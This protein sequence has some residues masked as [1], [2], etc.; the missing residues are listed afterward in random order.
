LATLEHWR[1]QG[2]TAHFADMR[3]D[4]SGAWGEVAMTAI[5][6]AARMDARR[7]SERT[8]AVASYLRSIGRPHGGNL[9]LD[10]GTLVIRGMAGLLLLLTSGT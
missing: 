3:L 7:T 10:L 6:A 4:M 5:A 9:P 1:V 2:V 8:K